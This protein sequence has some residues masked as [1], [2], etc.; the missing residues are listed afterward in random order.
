MAVTS[1]GASMISGV[2]HDG[3]AGGRRIGVRQEARG[4][5]HHAERGEQ[6]RD[7]PGGERVEERGHGARIVDEALESCRGPV[8][9]VRSREWEGRRRSGAA[10][11][12]ACSPGRSSWGRSCCWRPGPAA[13]DPAASP[14]ARRAGQRLTLRR[15]P[16]AIGL[17]RVVAGRIGIARCLRGPGCRVRDRRARAAARRPAARRRGD[18]ALEPARQA[19]VG[20]LHGQLVPAVSR[21]AAD[22]ERPTPRATRT[23]ASSCW[24]STCAR[25]RRSSTRSSASS[26]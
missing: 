22:H 5:Q 7:D 12:R 25:T 9:L 8:V 6:R 13:P 19:R 3:R 21:R 24:R 18:R 2:G 10:S 11:S 1:D 16:V 17:D 15:R 23:P 14:D 4:D 26:T 20:Q